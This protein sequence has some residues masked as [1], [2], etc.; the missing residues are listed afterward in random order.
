MVFGIGSSTYTPAQ[1]LAQLNGVT[2]NGRG[3]LLGYITNYTDFTTRQLYIEDGDNALK[4][5]EFN[6]TADYTLVVQGCF[7]TN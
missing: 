6:L 3:Y 5:T 7:V 1:T 2:A 4:L